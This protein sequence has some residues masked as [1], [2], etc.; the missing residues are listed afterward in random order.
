MAA[1]QVAGCPASNM[2]H[3]VG[4]VAPSGE[5][6]AGAHDALSFLS[7]I[8]TLPLIFPQTLQACCTRT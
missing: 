7:T 1:S 6:Q 4:G 8:E 3:G 5:S 2:E